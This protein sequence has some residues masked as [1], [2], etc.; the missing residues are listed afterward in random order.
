MSWRSSI[1]GEAESH[2]GKPLVRHLEGTERLARTLAERQGLPEEDRHGLSEAALSHD[3]G[4]LDPDFQAYL[5]KER[6]EGVPHAFPSA[7][8]TL[9]LTKDLWAAEVVARH[10]AGFRNADGP[11]S[12]MRSAWF[13]AVVERDRT[14]A[15]MRRLLPDFEI[16]DAAAWMRCLSPA[17]Q[18]MDEHRWR[19]CRALASLLV[20]A[21][22]MDALDIPEEPPAALPPFHM[23][24]TAARSPDMDEWRQMLHETC[25]KNAQERLEAPGVY[26]LSLP[27][28][29][30]KTLIGLHVAHLAAERFGAPNIVYALPFISIVEQNAQV[31]ASVFA[32]EVQE[33]HSLALLRESSK[34]ER[35][36]EETPWERMLNLFRY[37]RAPVV[38]TTTAHL[39]RALF[40]FHANA[41]MNFHRLCRSVVLLDE[42]QGI[43]PEL[44]NG[45]GRILSHLSETWKTTFLLMTATQ[46]RIVPAPE[47]REL[48]PPTVRFPKNRHNYRF[49]PGKH[50]LEDLPMLLEEGVPSFRERSGL[51]VCNTKRSAYDVWRTL[52]EKLPGEIVLFLSRAQAPRHRA[53]VLRYLRLLEHRGLRHFLVSTQV[54]EAGVDLDFDWVFRDLGPLDSVVQAAGRCNRHA[55]KEKTGHVMVAELKG[56]EARRPFCE[57]VYSSTLLA[58]TRHRLSSVETF[59]EG[60]V[61]SLVEAYYRDVEDRTLPSPDLWKGGI[62]EGRWARFPDLYEKPL[63]GVPVVVELDR[64]VRPLLKEFLAAP[65]DLANVERRKLLRRR[66]QQY[67]VEI[68]EKSAQ[69]AMEVAGNIVTE[70]DTPPLAP[71]GKSDMLFLSRDA[72]GPRGERGAPDH[73][74]RGLLAHGNA[75]V[76][77]GTPWLYDLRTGFLPYFEEEDHAALFF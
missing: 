48:A 54:V 65:R 34:G 43:R 10:H 69:R 56:E 3:L 53:R 27:T 74:L 12:D 17:G 26:S 20:A 23:P 45:L 51:V 1:P 60:A 24:K 18:K 66:I 7:L 13:E 52:R 19:R 63:P 15:R 32:T 37:W 73:T 16:P 67:Q 41:T 9:C 33:D 4:K 11:M 46:P 21:D 36:E 68:S 50:R 59:D 31:A 77:G 5:R 8:F 6:R 25:M 64:S 70:S 35:Q 22:R 2:P 40:D 14:A 38:V 75:P 28:G 72:L 61:S 29:A 71:V 39:W 44:W 76:P 42:P 47:I 55:S 57:Y 30:G 58:A 62:E 49:V